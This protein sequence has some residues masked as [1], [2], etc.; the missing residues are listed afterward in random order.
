MPEIDLKGSPA[1]GVAFAPSS[2]FV[3]GWPS[4]P[5]AILLELAA[6]ALLWFVLKTLFNSLNRLRGA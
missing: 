1:P 5:H 6:V 3:D 2:V 4:G